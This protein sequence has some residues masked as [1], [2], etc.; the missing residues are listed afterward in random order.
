MSTIN[1]NTKYDV[2]KLGRYEI[3][4]II[5][6]DNPDLGFLCMIQKIDSST[7]FVK[8]QSTLNGIKQ[9]ENIFNDFCFSFSYVNT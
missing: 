6:N 7:I 5:N 3:H 1:Q 8:M 4:H 2:N 9:L